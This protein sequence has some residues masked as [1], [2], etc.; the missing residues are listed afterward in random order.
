MT[1][2]LFFTTRCQETE[3]LE[4]EPGSDR[5]FRGE[6]RSLDEEIADWRPSRRPRA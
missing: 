4:I 2:F 1:S 3:F 5:S 6:V